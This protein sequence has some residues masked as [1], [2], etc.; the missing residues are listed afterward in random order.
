MTETMSPT[1]DLA[2]AVDAERTAAEALSALEDAA[3]QGQDV[4]P[5]DISGAA[6]ALALRRLRREQLEADAAAAEVDAAAAARDAVLD[7]LA[8]QAAAE[9]ALDHARLAEL[10]ATALSAA[11]NYLAAVRQAE[12]AFSALARQ[13]Q[14]AGL[15]LAE[16][17]DPR[18]DAV[19][20][21]F[22]HRSGG[23]VTY[24][25]TAAV[26]LRGAEYRPPRPGLAEYFVR[27]VT[28]QT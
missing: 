16:R 2:A 20:A 7:R 6:G 14:A 11:T 15:P 1:D 5:S 22:A 8:A 28:G 12:D 21:G 3:R 4:D 23:A 10:E 27:R 18:P 17:T 13:A 24:G 26:R 25:P 9:P 19:V